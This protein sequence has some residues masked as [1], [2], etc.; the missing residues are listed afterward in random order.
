MLPLSSS[1]A[2][3]PAGPLYRA[4]WRWHFYAGI[5][6][7]P[8]AI[9]LAITGAIYLW[10]PQYEAWRHRALLAVP[11]G[12]AVVPA[13][14]QLAAARAAVAPPLRAQSFQ[15]AAGPGATAVVVFRA[16]GA[17]AFSPGLNVYVDPHTGQ[18]V[19]QL[20]DDATLMTKV[21]NLHGSLLAGKFGKYAV[22]LAA[23]WALVLFLTG[24]YLAWPRPRFT[25]W[26][27]LLPRLRARGRPFW[28]DL[29]AVPAVWLSLATVFLLSTGL[30]WTQ[31][32]GAWYRK[33]SAW[34]GQGTPRESSSGAHRSDLTGWSPPLRAGLAE[35]V[36]RLAST[37]PHDHSMHG[38]GMS[39]PG[40]AAVPDGPFPGAMTLDAAM[41][42]ARDRRV[43]EPFV[44]GLPV[45]P[46]GVFSVISDRAQPFRRAYLHLDQYS[47]RVLAD[48]R[49]RDFGYLAQFFSWGIVAHEG[50]LFGLANQIL[51][52]LAAGGVVLLGVSGLALWWQ[53]RP[54]RESGRPTEALSLPRPV[55]VGT[56]ALAVALPL[57]AASLVA[58]FLGERWLAWRRAS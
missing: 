42:S 27:F 28:R 6:V 47:G 12:T 35:Q 32:A 4:V 37:P 55:W 26:G 19:G 23:S 43:P 11:A 16:A 31:G 38:G 1:P 18:V 10:K 34:S 21:K 7:A 57:L 29:H 50:Q 52:T 14:R 25:P 48:V 54:A 15:P 56:L 22:E 3:T 45:G 41:A 33:I 30:L 9:F 58:L 46:A 44:V 17:S 20:R 24:L 39:A 49:F 8:F 2:E 5:V 51:G 40:G 13:D 53:R 36:D